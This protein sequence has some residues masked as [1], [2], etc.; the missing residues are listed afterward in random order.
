[1]HGPDP[2]ACFPFPGAQHTIFIKN[3]IS[4]SNISAGDYSYYNDPVEPER[5]QEKCVRYHFDFIGDKLA[6]GKFC[7][8]A[9]GVQFIMN[10]ANHAMTGFSTF[11]F[12]IFQNGWEKGFDF[13]TITQ[14]LRGDT[15]V[16][17]DVWIGTNATILPGVSIGHGAIV[18]T[19]AVVASNVPDYAIVAGNPAKVIR[20]RFDQETIDA[21]LEI[22]WWDWPI[23]KIS[24]HL[25]D[26][27]GADLDRLFAA[28]NDTD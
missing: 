6:I 17:N 22:A 16:G 24:R 25:D 15:V 14:G 12:N 4:G 20:R 23:D 5:F 28:N 27:R 21:L 7:A 19:K 13:E 8:L 9:T 26:I 1:M 10:G 11:P 3:V 18:G 2:S